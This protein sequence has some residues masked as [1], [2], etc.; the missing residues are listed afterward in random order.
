M[1]K[2]ILTLITA[3]LLTLTC[4][5]PGLAAPR[6]DT[7]KP[8]VYYQN[9]V[10]VLLY[11]NLDKHENGITITPQRFQQHL[12][13]LQQKGYNVID[14][15]TLDLFLQGQANIPPNA[16]LITFDDGYQS[17][18]QYAYPVLKKRHMPATLFVIVNHMGATDREIPKVTWEEARE[19]QDAGCSIQSHS[20][21]SHAEIT[22]NELG[23]TGPALTSR[24][25]FRDKRHF[26]SE[27]EYQERI[28]KDLALSRSVLL[29]E[30]GRPM[31]T[32]LAV[33][34][35]KENRSVEE[36]AKKIGFKYIFTTVPGL[37]DAKTTPT[38]LN[39]I[40][41]GQ[42]GLSAQSLHRRIMQYTEDP[43]EHLD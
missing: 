9:Q 39:R 31:S 36:I 35:G 38:Q 14:L 27:Y 30:L 24:I 1:K 18:Y 7:R 26:E 21:D 19:M 17:V 37:I 16:V 10:A 43:E 6:H 4:A 32:S 23:D 20:Y 8:Q 34:L 3:V 12:D 41:A 2:Y 42:A 29:D 15:K 13:M 33:P 22:I 25:Y 5:Q 28:E 11:H 40:N